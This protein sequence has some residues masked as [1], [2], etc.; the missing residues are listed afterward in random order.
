[1]KY[2]K[3]FG[4]LTQYGFI[5]Q[6]LLLMVPEKLMSPWSRQPKV[7]FQFPGNNHERK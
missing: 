7:L 2:Y 3:L 6:N 5:S 1:M 4:L